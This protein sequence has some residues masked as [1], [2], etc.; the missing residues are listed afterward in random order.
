MND[1]TQI[2]F[3][4]VAAAGIRY[5]ELEDWVLIIAWVADGHAAAVEAGVDDTRIV[6]ATDGGNDGAEHRL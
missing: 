4:T 5:A 2:G 1:T 3:R 6:T